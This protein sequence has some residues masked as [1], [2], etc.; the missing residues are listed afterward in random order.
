LNPE[1]EEINL[2]ITVEVEVRWEEVSGEIVVQTPDNRS[3]QTNV[4]Q[5]LVRIGEKLADVEDK[6]EQKLE[7]KL[8]QETLK[9]MFVTELQA[10]ETIGIWNLTICPYKT[11]GYFSR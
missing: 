6:L 7:E 9:G 10:F 11:T 4:E 3:G 8:A 1:E 5:K 2:D